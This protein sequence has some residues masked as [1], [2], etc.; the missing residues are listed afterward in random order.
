M[1]NSEPSFVSLKMNG[2]GKIRWFD[3]RRGYGFIIPDEGG[4]DIFVHRRILQV[5]ARL[6]RLEPG[7]VVDYEAQHTTQGTK[8]TRVTVLVTAS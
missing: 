5:S 7:Q 4:P 2:T 1:V 8:A 3:A 6:R